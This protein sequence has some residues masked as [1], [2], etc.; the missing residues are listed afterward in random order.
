[1]ILDWR[2]STDFPQQR[3]SF[4][5]KGDNYLCLS[6][7]VQVQTTSYTRHISTKKNIFA[8]VTFTGLS[9]SEEEF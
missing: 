5:W 9:G 8:D 4:I 2:Q 7:I 6:N 1:M 3:F